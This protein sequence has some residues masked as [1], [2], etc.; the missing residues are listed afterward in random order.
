L[1]FHESNISPKVAAG[2]GSRIVQEDHGRIEVISVVGKGS[3]FEVVLPFH[4]PVTQ[5]ATS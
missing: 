5:A 2:P 4:V 3:S 1:A